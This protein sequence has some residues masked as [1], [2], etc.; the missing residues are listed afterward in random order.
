MYFVVLCNNFF[1]YSPGQVGVTGNKCG[2]GLDWC[3]VGQ[4]GTELD[5]LGARI[6]AVTRCQLG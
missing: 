5:S 1:D 2:T 6:S 3:R 4:T